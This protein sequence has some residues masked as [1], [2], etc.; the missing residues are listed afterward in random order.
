MPDVSFT[1]LLVVA[2]VGSPR[3]VRAV[4]SPQRL[5]VTPRTSFRPC[6]P[7][8]R[9]GVAI[10]RNVVDSGKMNSDPGRLPLPGTIQKRQQRRPVPVEEVTSVDA[11]APA[12][13][14]E[15]LDMVRAGLGYLAAADTTQLPAATQAGCLRELGAGRR[16]PHR[17][18][19]VD[20]AMPLPAW[21]SWC[22][23][24]SGPTPCDARLRRAA[25]RVGH[26][27]WEISCTTIVEEDP[28]HHR[29]RALCAAWPIL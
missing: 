25:G 17:R 29:C 26:S 19:G 8:R 13:A 18:A 28:P 3:P 16:G 15:A 4:A 10:R 20:P 21:L 23:L 1:N 11:M 12:N 14:R 7:I 5:L 22:L 2:A 9:I 27:S 6:V 24:S